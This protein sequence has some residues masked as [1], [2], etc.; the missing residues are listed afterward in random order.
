MNVTIVR[1]FVFNMME[2]KCIQLRLTVKEFK[3]HDHCRKMFLGEYWSESGS[4]VKTK[5]IHLCICFKLI[6]RS[7]RVAYHDES[8]GHLVSLDMTNQ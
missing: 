1:K 4:I 5:V 3:M 2:T 6:T 7:R 8:V